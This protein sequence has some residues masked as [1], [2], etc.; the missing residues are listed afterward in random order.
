MERE[1]VM[2]LNI[3]DWMGVKVMGFSRWGLMS[4]VGER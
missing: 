4:V 2:V 3:R 1:R